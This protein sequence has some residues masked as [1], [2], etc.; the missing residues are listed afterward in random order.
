MSEAHTFS[1]DED[2]GVEI[3]SETYI[4]DVKRGAPCTI[5]IDHKPS[6]PRPSDFGDVVSPHLRRLI[7]NPAAVP[8]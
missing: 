5:S 2:Q 1:Y 7:E 4:S 6:T 8:R 3:I